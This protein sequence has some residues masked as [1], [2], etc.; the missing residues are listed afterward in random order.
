MC[1]GGGGGGSRHHHQQNHHHQPKKTTTT[2]KR[3]PNSKWGYDVKGVP[4]NQ[5]KVLF[6]A[7]NFWGRTMA[8]VSTSQDASS[9]EG[10]G[11]FMP[12]F[13]VI[14]YDDLGALRA[15]L[16]ADPNIVA[17]MVEP[18]QVRFCCLLGFFVVGFFSVFFFV[19]SRVCE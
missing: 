13:E 11:P 10:F 19:F 5:A 8:A 16:E 7:G 9:Y 15:A 14:P 6:A 12:G 18:I 17:F 4:K 3:P 2:K 1:S